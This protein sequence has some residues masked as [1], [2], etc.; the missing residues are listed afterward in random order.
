[1]KI[2]TQI[3]N[4]AIPNII[5]N[6]TV[7][8]LGMVDIAIAGHIGNEIYIGAIAVAGTIFNF[9][10]WNFGF[11]RMGTTGLT[12]QAL[13]ARNY[14][15][16]MRVFIRAVTVG[17]GVAAVVVILQDYILWLALMAIGSSDE[18]TRLATEYFYV[19]IWAAPA[20]LLMYVFNGWFIGM[21]NT[22]L[23]M[24]VAIFINIL[25]VVFS[26]LFA[27]QME[28]GL[29][30]VA[31]GTVVAQYGGL[32]LSII[33][34]NV[35]YGRL[36]RYIHFVGS[37]R[38][39]D[40]GAFFVVNRD[41]FLRTLC[42]IVVFTFFTSVSAKMGDAVLAV[43]TLILQLFTL[44]SYVMDGFAHAG[45][46]LVG[47]FIGS[48]NQKMLNA[49]IKYTNLWGAGFAVLFVAGYAAFGDL[50]IGIMTDSEVI[51]QILP[52]YFYW[53]LLVPIAGYMAFI[54]DGILVGATATGIMRNAM[55]ISTAVFF[56]VY[57]SL[58]DIM[59]NDSLW[60]AFIVYLFLRG[61]LQYIISYKKLKTAAMLIECK[62]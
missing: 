41:I 35:Y 33:L 48:R 17:I 50:I 46:A 36:R 27:I 14:R 42:L 6:I 2:N 58:V 55:F 60:L 7:P 39:K 26:L 24:W 29:K 22:R 8:L 18:V 11:L 45:E 5:S 38:L 40:M 1:M 28:M 57:Y 61:V 49:A 10:Y 15:E 16:A 31:L 44:F 25:N 51:F 56:I 37:L 21:Q 62:N 59:G 34:W 4:L 43:N 23:P 3:L 52:Q 20:A 47:K 32:L 53:I 13:G 12:A 9:I 19:R 54:Y 30:G